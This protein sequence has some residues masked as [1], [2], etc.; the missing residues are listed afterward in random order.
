V[1]DEPLRANVDDQIV[2]GRRRGGLRRGY[3]REDYPCQ[4][5]NEAMRFH[6]ASDPLG[7]AASSRPRRRRLSASGGLGTSKA[8][9]SEATSADTGYGDAANLAWLVHEKRI[10][11]HIPVFERERTDGSFDRA[12][13]AYDHRR[14]LYT[15]PGGKELRRYWQDGRAAKVKPPIDG[16][17]KYRARKADWDGYDFR[18]R[19][20]PGDAGRKLLRSIHEGAR[21]LARDM[22]LTDAYLTSRR[23]RKK[24]EMLFAHSSAS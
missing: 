5:R 13:F 17:Y 8:L 11:P 3:P 1:S 23:E 22:S 21:N 7:V 16:I 12:D 10:E 19:C 6:K 9:T 24:V 18:Q 15:C 20:R 14:A 2:G 4:D